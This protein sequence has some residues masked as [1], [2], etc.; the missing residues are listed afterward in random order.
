M[1]GALSIRSGK[2]LI[3]PLRRRRC[4]LAFLA[5]TNSYRA[6]FTRVIYTEWL[7]FALLAAGIF[8]LHRRGQY[9]PRYLRPLYPLVPAVSLITSAAIAANQIRATPLDSILGL[10]LILLGLPVYFV[11]AHR[12]TNKPAAEL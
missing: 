10:G 11:W 6:L 9:R 1:D 7:F 3:W 8:V 2:L 5:A 12:S 4:G